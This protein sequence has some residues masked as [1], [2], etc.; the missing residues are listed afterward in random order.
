L[1]VCAIAL[2][3]PLNEIYMFRRV[4]GKKTPKVLMT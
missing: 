2:S 4:L 1:D 3:I